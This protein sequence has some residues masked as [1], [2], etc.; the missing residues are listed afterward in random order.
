MVDRSVQE[1]VQAMDDFVDN[2]LTALV[3]HTFDRIND[4]LTRVEQDV[5]QL[6]C[7]EEGVI[8]QL[9]LFIDEKT[10]FLDCGCVFKVKT[11]W[12]QPCECTCSDSLPTKATCHC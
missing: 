1:I 10:D 9:E 8:K 6:V 4:L 2:H 5:Q 3:D 11:A 12:A 7:E